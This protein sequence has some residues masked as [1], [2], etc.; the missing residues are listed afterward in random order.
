MTSLEFPRLQ[1]AVAVENAYAISMQKGGVG[2]TTASICIAAAAARRQRKTLLVDLDPQA[3][4]T[5]Y[6]KYLLK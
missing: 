3:S 4:A 2:K 1:D 6:F 5:R